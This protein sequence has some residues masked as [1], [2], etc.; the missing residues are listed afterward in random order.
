MRAGPRRQDLWR[1]GWRGD[2][3]LLRGQARC[4]PR[5]PAFFRLPR[6]TILLFLRDW[7]WH[8]LALMKSLATRPLSHSFFIQILI[9][10]ERTRRTA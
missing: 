8:W 4:G 3:I 6:R 2:E 9:E 7:F 5:R 10:T 1:G